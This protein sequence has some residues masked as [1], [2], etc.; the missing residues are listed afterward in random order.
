M[1]RLLLSWI[2]LHH[3]H[4]RGFST[5]GMLFSKS[6]LSLHAIYK[7]VPICQLTVYHWD[8]KGENGWWTKVRSCPNPVS[9]LH[10]TTHLGWFTRTSLSGLL[11]IGFVKCAFHIFSIFLHIW[12]KGCRDCT[13]YG[14]M[15]YPSI[16]LH[17]LLNQTF[18][19]FGLTITHIINFL[20]VPKNHETCER[21]FGD[22]L[23]RADVGLVL[24]RKLA[25][26]TRFSLSTGF[27]RRQSLAPLL[28]LPPQSPSP[29]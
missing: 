11:Y 29:P 14:R 28:S 16:P 7:M 3:G 10:H 13:K 26:V 24:Q 9:T 2:L 27:T 15:S 22:L 4:Y 21:I 18:E 19:N 8:Q 6:V 12:F 1:W 25:H 23:S 5:F 20:T 17:H